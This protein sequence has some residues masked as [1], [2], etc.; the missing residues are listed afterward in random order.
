MAKN[1]KRFRRS[2]RKSRSRKSARFAAKVADAITSPQ[3]YTQEIFSYHLLPTSTAALGS[4]NLYC[5]GSIDV[6]GGGSVITHG[7]SLF[8]VNHLLRIA[9]RINSGAGDLSEKFY[10]MHGLLQ[11]HLSNMNNFRV[12]GTAWY[13]KVR[14]DLG[15]T[16]AL[17]DCVHTLNDGFIRNGYGTDATPTGLSQSELTPYQSA[18]YVTAYN[19]TKKRK[20]SLRPGANRRFTL[21]SS[22]KWR[23]NPQVFILPH[24][25][26]TTWLTAPKALSWARGDRFILF[27][28]QAISAI[29]DTTTVQTSTPG[30]V[31]IMRTINRIGYKTVHENATHIYVQAP[32]GFS[33]AVS[34]EF[35]SEGYHVQTLA[36]SSG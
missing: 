35:V 3:T 6:V 32:V 8:G 7:N 19:I 28:F 36:G 12:F 22:K 15:N 31:I 17:D 24:D 33:T 10:V 1:R 4:G 18:T 29:N 16:G 27:Q 34:P 21:A 11:Y 9:N 5:T 26:T 30:G 13:C 2:S 14:R 20:F 23:C 25:Q